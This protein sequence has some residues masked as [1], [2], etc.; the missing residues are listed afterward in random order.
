MGDSDR[1][2]TVAISHVRVSA[3]RSR[4]SSPQTGQNA[5]GSLQRCKCIQAN[6]IAVSYLSVVAQGYSEGFDLEGGA[7]G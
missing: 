5:A 6:F 7:D 3:H 2:N 4:L 1:Q